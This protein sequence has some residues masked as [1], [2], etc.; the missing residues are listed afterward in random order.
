MLNPIPPLNRL[1][2][3]RLLNVETSPI[4]P[5]QVDPACLFVKQISYPD[6]GETARLFEASKH[7]VEGLHNQ[8]ANMHASSTAV[9]AVSKAGFAPVDL[10]KRCDTDSLDKGPQA[11]VC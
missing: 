9:M 6:P 11:S 5:S 2:R 1:Q 3:R 4:Q 10:L 7:C 8:N